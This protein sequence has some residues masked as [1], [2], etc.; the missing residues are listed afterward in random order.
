MLK[1]LIIVAMLA[2]VIPSSKSAAQTRKEAAVLQAVEALR[3]A[4][5]NSDSAALAHLA[6]D[7]LS[8]GH[9]HGNVQ[10]KQAFIQ[11]FTSGSSDFV[12]IDLTDQTV[13][14]FDKTAVV[15]HTLSAV[16]NDRGV[17]GNV[18]LAILLVWH[19]E[20]GDWRLIARQAVRL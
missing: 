9:S 3:T 14:V 7:R 12:S 6:S 1:K 10:N 19:K 8:Y 20:K 5:I 16:T 18:K 13:T 17:P 4:M 2:S 15:R 11:A